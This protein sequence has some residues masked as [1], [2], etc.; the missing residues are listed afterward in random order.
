MMMNWDMAIDDNV[1]KR[2]DRWQRE[3]AKLMK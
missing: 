2:C 3:L 1:K